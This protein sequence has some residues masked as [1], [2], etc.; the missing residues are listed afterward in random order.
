[1]QNVNIPKRAAQMRRKTLPREV[2]GLAS[3]LEGICPVVEEAAAQEKMYPMM[4]MIVSLIDPLK[5]I[6]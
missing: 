6:K 3:H 5:T 1:M 2:E 4:E